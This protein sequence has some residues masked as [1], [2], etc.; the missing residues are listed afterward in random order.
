MTLDTNLRNTRPIGEAAARL[1]RCTAA[2]AFRLDEG[3]V[4]TVIPCAQPDQMA[5]QLRTLLR[6]LLQ[7]ATASLRDEPAATDA[8]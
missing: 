2:P 8:Q 3:P 1:G 4:P 6:D 7:R 5:G